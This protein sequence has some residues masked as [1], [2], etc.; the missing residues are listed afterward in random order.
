MKINF[1]SVITCLLIS[2]AG[3]SQQD[4]NELYDHYIHIADSLY[5]SKDYRTSALNYSKAFES[6]GWKGTGP[7]RYNAAC[8]WAL[9]GNADSAFYQLN[10]LAEKRNYSNYQWI[11]T[12]VDLISLKSDSRWEPL[13][14]KVQ[15]NKELIE[16]DFDKPLV[17]Q[18]DSILMNDQK[19]RKQL[20]SIQKIYGWDSPQIEN[21]WKLINEKDSINLIKVLHI[22]DTKGWLGPNIIGGQGNS[23]LFL[24][25]QHSDLKTQKKYLPMM[26]V[27][28]KKGNAKPSDLALLEDRVALGLGKKQTYGSQIG[29]N[30]ENGEMYVLPLKDPDNVDKR[31]AEMQLPTLGEYTQYF[32]FS[33]DL[34][35]Y[36]KNLPLYVKMN[37]KNKR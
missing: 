34:E 8:T 7:D 36:K 12:D 19:Y 15:S 9:A 25:I 26:R 3:F 16:K 28:A 11:S 6:L 30:P 24:V 2:F 14:A 13:L 17:A 35:T 27:A 4:P 31:R 22:L 18:L 10:N 20:D 37:K 5:D 23:T 1:S 29:R 33:W 21:Q 32:G